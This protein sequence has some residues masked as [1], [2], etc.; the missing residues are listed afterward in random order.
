MS[1]QKYVYDLSDLSVFFNPEN[2]MSI[3]SLH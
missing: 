3:P 2:E 1:G